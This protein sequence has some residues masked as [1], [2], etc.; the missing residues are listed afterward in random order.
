MPEK[1]DIYKALTKKSND[2]I[3]DSQKDIDKKRKGYKVDKTGAAMRQ[4]KRGSFN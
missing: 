1:K 3:A 2:R 4:S